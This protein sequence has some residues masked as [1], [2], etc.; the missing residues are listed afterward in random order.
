[1][2]RTRTLTAYLGALAVGQL[3]LYVRWVAKPDSLCFD[4][5]PR[6]GLFVLQ[7][8][9]VGHEPVGPARLGWAAAVLGGS[10]QVTYITA[11]GRGVPGATLDDLR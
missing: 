10:S 4:L 8:M 11:S 6:T 7:T 2:P 3:G 1:M 9:L 5:D